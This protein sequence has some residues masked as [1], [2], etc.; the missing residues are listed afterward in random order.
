MPGK[1]SPVRLASIGVRKSLPGRPSDIPWQYPPV[2]QLGHFKQNFMKFDL[3]SLASKWGPWRLLGEEAGYEVR[4]MVPQPPLGEEG[5]FKKWQKKRDF[6]VLFNKKLSKKKYGFRRKWRKTCVG[7]KNWFMGGHL[8]AASPPA[9]SCTKPHQLHTLWVRMSQ[10]IWRGV[11]WKSSLSPRQAPLGFNCM[12]SICMYTYWIYGL[13]YG[14]NVCV[15]HTHACICNTNTCIWA[16]DPP[17][18]HAPTPKKIALGGSWPPTCGAPAGSQCG[19]NRPGFAAQAAP[20]RWPGA[21]P[22]WRGSGVTGSFRW[23]KGENCPHNFS[24]RVQRVRF[25]YY[26]YNHIASS[27][28]ITSDHVITSLNNYIIKI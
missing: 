11:S 4:G 20:S 5:G 8:D 6:Q 15:L 1:L 18:G 12:K 19:W 17:A 24:T 9:S 3:D 16:T 25:S 10:I 28:V 22:R 23:A 26:Y 7:K 2:S 21:W 14:C 27:H 13:V